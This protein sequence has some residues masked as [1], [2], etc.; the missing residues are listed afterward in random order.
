MLSNLAAPPDGAH[1]AQ[2]GRSHLPAIWISSNLHIAIQTEM[3][4]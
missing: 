4:A 3:G 2:S 1:N